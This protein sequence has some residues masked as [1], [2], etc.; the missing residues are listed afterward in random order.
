MHIRRRRT[1]SKPPRVLL[2]ADTTRG[3]LAAVRSVRAGGYEPWLALWQSGTL[4]GRSR[5]GAGTVSVPNPDDD[6]ES[7]ARELAN[8]AVQL[9]A[10]AVLPVTENSLVAIAMSDGH[11]HFPAGVALGSPAP[12]TVAR[13]TDKRVLASIAASVGLET[14]PSV[15]LDATELPARE[16]ELRFP[17][18]LKPARSIVDAG[19]RKI[20]RVDARLIDNVEHLRRAVGGRP[21]RRWLVQPFL[22]GTLAGVGGVSWKGELVCAL[23]QVMPRIWPPRCGEAAYS[24]TVPRD[25]QLERVIARMLAAIGWSGVFQ[26]QF[27]RTKERSYLID[28]NPRVYRSLPLST[29][30]GMNLVAIWL[31]LLLGRVPAIGDY[32]VGVAWRDDLADARALVDA[33]RKGQRR[34]ALKAALP[35]RHTVHAVFSLRDPLPFVFGFA[36]GAP[37][38]A[39]AARRR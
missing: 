9:G 32:R 7:F 20:R 17:A 3:S 18:V 25:T 31:D 2:T 29:A 10:A 5:A 8:A 33:F 22:A 30:A 36:Q 11:A 12:E 27:L 34:D 35:R 26:L 6:P 24:L 21:D 23:H 14:P 15:E 19:D 1:S 13:A 16:R 37:Q 39:R 28:L 4:A 38:L